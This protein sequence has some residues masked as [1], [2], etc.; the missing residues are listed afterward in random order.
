MF[1]K[2]KWLQRQE[3]DDDD[4]NKL[5]DPCTKSACKMSGGWNLCERDMN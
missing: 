5:S 4:K 1:R 2:L 3:N